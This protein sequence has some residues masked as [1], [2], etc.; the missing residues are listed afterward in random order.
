[1]HHGLDGLAHVADIFRGALVGRTVRVRFR[2][3]RADDVPSDPAA[4]ASW[5]YDEWQ[6]EDDWVAAQA[7]RG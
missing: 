2:R 5:L 4:R 6:R 7:A 3:V 1:V